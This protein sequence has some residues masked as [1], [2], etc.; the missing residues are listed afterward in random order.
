MYTCQ[1]YINEFKKFHAS[2]LTNIEFQPS[3]KQLSLEILGSIEGCKIANI[4]THRLRVLDLGLK[5]CNGLSFLNGVLTISSFDENKIISVYDV[6]SLNKKIFK[7]EREFETR[8][9]G[10]FGICMNSASNLFICDSLND[11]VVVVDA[12]QKSVLHVFGKSGSQPGEFDAACDI[13]HFNGSIYV[14]DSGNKRI[15]E[16]S[17]DGTYK[18]EI[19]L[20]KRG[21]E[22]LNNKGFIRVFLTN[23]VRFEINKDAIAVVDNFKELYIYAFDGKIM[24]IIDDVRNM[25]F[26]NTNLFTCSSDGILKCYEKEVVDSTK[27]YY[28]VLYMRLIETLKMHVSFMKAIHGHLMFSL[29]DSKRNLMIL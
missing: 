12:K 16:F 17:F 29:N 7:Q 22:K 2:K 20:H 18:R 8:L 21:I 25:C 4:L 14:L 6:F 19:K 1:E 28:S 15:Q 5:S 24:Q 3:E 11:R 23:P 9:N 10:P 13:C 27:V 26:L